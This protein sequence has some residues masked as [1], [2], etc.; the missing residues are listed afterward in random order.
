MRLQGERERGGGSQHERARGKEGEREDGR[1]GGR[2]GGRERD[3]GGKDRE[4]NMNR[5]EH[6]VPYS[7]AP[8]LHHPISPP[9]ARIPRQA[10][11]GKG[12]ESSGEATSLRQPLFSTEFSCVDLE[13]VFS[14]Q[15]LSVRAEKIFDLKRTHH[16]LPVTCTPPGCAVVLPPAADCD[17]N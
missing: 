13:K 17:V 15:S 11:T 12:C 10:G 4:H 16:L 5:Y 9:L 3:K 8:C 7:Q 6:T 14:R 1:E 2:E